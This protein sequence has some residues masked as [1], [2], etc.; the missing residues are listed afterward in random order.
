MIKPTSNYRHTDNAKM[1]ERVRAL[2]AKAASTNFPEEADAFRAKADELMTNYSINLWQVQ[3]AQDGV[4][5]TVKPEA[6]EFDWSWWSKGADLYRSALS[7]IFQDVVHHCR[8]QM[9]WDKQNWSRDNGKYVLKF[10]VVG[11]PADLDYMDMLFTHLMMD[12]IRQVDPLPDPEQGLIENCQRLRL[13]GLDWFEITRRLIDAGMVEDPEP[14]QPWRRTG[15]WKNRLPLRYRLSERLG[16]QTRKWAKANDERTGYP[17]VKTYRRNFSLGYADR[18]NARL[19]EMCRSSTAAYDRGHEAGS[20]ALAVRDIREVVRAEVYAI[21]PDLAPHEAGCRCQRCKDRRKPVRG[22]KAPEYAY[23]RNAMRAGEQAGDR[24]DLASAPG[25]RLR[26]T[27]E[28][29]R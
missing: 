22:R 24:V 6:R 21:W 20:M 10:P 1:L 11:L 7:N 29:Q 26:S 25:S 14:G 23:D 5:R 27:P 18:V 15:G 17:H 16:S 9:V 19:R 12:L 3:M 13:A 28:L 4:Q 8:C 2:L